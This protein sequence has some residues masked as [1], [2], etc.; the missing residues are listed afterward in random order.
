[1]RID[2]AN[3][4]GHFGIDNQYSGKIFGKDRIGHTIGVNEFC[5]PTSMLAISDKGVK[6]PMARIA[7]KSES[8]AAN[9]GR[10]GHVSKSSNSYIASTVR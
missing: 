8:N 4:G 9:I 5:L 1:M 7:T 6:V 10:A 3:L 2:S